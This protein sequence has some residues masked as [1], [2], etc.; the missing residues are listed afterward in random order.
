MKKRI[1][2]IALML[3]LGGA[4]VIKVRAQQL[5]QQLSDRL[6]T[7]FDSICTHYQIKGV[8]AAVYIPNAGM[9]KGAYGESYAGNPITTDMQ[10]GMGSNTKTHIS[11][12]LLK[13]QEQGKLDLDDSIGTWIQGYPN[14]NGQITIRQC[15]NHTSGLF[16]YMGNDAINDSIFG[17]P[18]KIW[19]MDEILLL[20][21]APNFAPGSSW[22][23]SNTNYII[24]GIII[25]EITGKPVHQ[26]MR[27]MI[28]DPAGLTHTRFYWEPSSDV[29]PH[30]WTMV[31]GGEKLTDMNAEPVSLID[32]LFSLA[33]SAGA[34]VTTAE[35][36][37]KFW[38]MLMSGQILSTTSMNEMLT[39]VT[40]NNTVSYGLGI[41][42][43]K[44]YSNGRSYHCH[45]GTFFGFIN[46]NMVDEVN[47]TTITTLTNQDSFNNSFLQVKLIPALHKV[48]L[49][50]PVGI[51][52]EVYNSNTIRMYPNPANDVLN[53]DAEQFTN[54]TAVSLYDLAGKEQLAATIEGNRASFSVA[55]LPTGL[56][57]A[58][59]R[60]SS[61]QIVHT[62]KIQVLE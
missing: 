42:R 57:I 23:Y 31:L 62:Q 25:R 10:M 40:L 46:E 27:E 14:I 59:I 12:L 51:A 32:N 53:I 26:A 24:A 34:M 18:D 38:H 17:H 6:Q 41:F 50:M 15:L 60:N 35:D 44:N 43:Y 16:D 33:S 8:T 13:L 54:A 39:M 21:G 9:W 61:G 19:T 29:M 52:E 2:T 11:A 30:Q 47:G 3:C 45:G 56:Y 28:L 37:A 49:Q 22:D 20:A 55:Q 1:F 7:V 5:P 48:T 4:S 58:R 36:N